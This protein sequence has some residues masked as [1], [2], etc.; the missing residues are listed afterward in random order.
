MTWDVCNGGFRQY[1]YNSFSDYALDALRMFKVIG[2]PL[3][4]AHKILVDAIGVLPSPYETDR[5]RRQE[6]LAELDDSV[7]Q[8]FD[9]LDGRVSDYAADFEVELYEWARQNEQA[10]PNYVD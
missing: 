1:F 10:F 9:V 3:D 8:Q 5:A 6:L 4:Y 2:E 7:L